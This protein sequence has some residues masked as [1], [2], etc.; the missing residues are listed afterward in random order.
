[1]NFFTAVFTR[2][3]CMT[4]FCVITELTGPDE[5]YVLLLFIDSDSW[6]LV[7]PETIRE[8]GSS[9]HEFCTEAHK[10]ISNYSY[11]YQS[12]SELGCLYMGYV[13]YLPRKKIVDHHIPV[14]DQT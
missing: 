13:L 3:D 11:Y 14:V 4:H 7:K 1:M 8:P 6:F 2:A 5:G 12:S 9:H 10:M